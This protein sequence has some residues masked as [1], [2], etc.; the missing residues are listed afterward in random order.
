MGL[1][2]REFLKLAGVTA[3]ALAAGVQAGE[4]RVRYIRYEYPL[5]ADIWKNHIEPLLLAHNVQLMHTGHSHLWNRSKVGAM[6]YL[7]TSNVGNSFGAGWEGF[8]PRAPWATFPEE[9]AWQ[10]QVAPLT[11]MRWDARAYPRF[12]EAHGRK[13]IAPSEANPMAHFE[14]REAFPFVASNDVTCFSILDTET[15]TVTSYAFDTRYPTRRPVIAFDR[16]TL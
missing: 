12:G 10:E 1:S 8:G 5:E 7:E 14:G 3:A 9:P 16:F 15:G 6:H 11:A 4:R 2:R 13:P